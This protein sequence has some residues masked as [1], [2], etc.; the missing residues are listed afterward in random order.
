MALKTPLTQL[1]LIMRQ[2]A[3]R[4]VEEELAS[5]MLSKAPALLRILFRGSVFVL[6]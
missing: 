6:L 5:T 2:A 4:I 1:I 3:Q